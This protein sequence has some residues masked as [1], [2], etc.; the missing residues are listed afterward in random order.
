MQNSNQENEQKTAPAFAHRRIPSKTII[1]TSQLSS[2][3][4][5]LDPLTSSKNTNSDLALINSKQSKTTEIRISLHE[6]KKNS[7]TIEHTPTLEIHTL[8]NSTD[9]KEQQKPNATNEK[10]VE[11]IAFKSQ[12]RLNKLIKKQISATPET[13]P[14]VH[15]T[16]INQQVTVFNI[17]ND[18]R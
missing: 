9:S 5:T 15:N 7:N 12:H 14:L 6:Q 3:L 10:E 17:R 13:S 8:T 2:Q 4:R 16:I 1:N 18:L 11:H